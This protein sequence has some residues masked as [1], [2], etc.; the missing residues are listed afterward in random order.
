MDTEEEVEEDK[1][2][3]EVE[4]RVEKK[5]VEM[6]G[7]EEEENEG[8]VEVLVEEGGGGAEGGSRVVTEGG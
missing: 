2:S 4:H 6:Q 8:E 1:R 7:I 3:V 5:K